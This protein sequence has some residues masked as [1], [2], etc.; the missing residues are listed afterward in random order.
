MEA[1]FKVLQLDP[2]FP[3]HYLDV[4]YEV[5][6]DRH[7]YFELAVVRRADGTSSRAASGW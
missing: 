6:D 5:V 1:I 2:G 4:R 3:H 7:G